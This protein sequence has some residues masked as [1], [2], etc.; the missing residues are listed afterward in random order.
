METILPALEA[1]LNKDNPK[2]GDVLLPGLTLQELEEAESMLGMQLQPEMRQLY[3][4][5]NGAVQGIE[6]FPGYAFYSLQE[7]ISLNKDLAREYKDRGLWLLMAHEAN[8]LTLFP[9]N[10]G[11]GY[12]YDPSRDYALGGVFFNFREA[13]YSILFPSIR[14]LLQAIV[15]CYQQGVYRNGETLDFTREQKILETYGQPITQ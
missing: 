5:H 9:D 14:N 15:D 4:W 13:G 6:I 8:W 3:Q 1:E 11:D 12:Y 10:A 7:A 2:I